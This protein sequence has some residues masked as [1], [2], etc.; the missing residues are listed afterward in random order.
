M[1]L[2]GIVLFLPLLIHNSEAVTNAT[3]LEIVIS[4]LTQVTNWF[5][6]IFDKDIPVN[7]D[8][9]ITPAIPRVIF[10]FIFFV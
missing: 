4:Q 8:K 7:S 2:F 3:P 1:K 10:I 6:E 9:P 5:S